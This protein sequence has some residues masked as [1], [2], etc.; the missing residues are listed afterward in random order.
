MCDV[1]GRGPNVEDVRCVVD[2]PHTIHCGYAGR[3]RCR[4]TDS[5][6]RPSDEELREWDAK[7]RE[8]HNHREQNLDDQCGACG[9][10][11]REHGDGPCLELVVQDATVDHY[12]C[13]A[14]TTGCQTPSP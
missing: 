5:G 8:R 14:F 6:E 9:H 11:Y 12:G 1:F 4:W 3:V 10:A 2:W 13:A 7:W